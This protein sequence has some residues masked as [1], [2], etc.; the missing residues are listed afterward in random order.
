ML[1]VDSLDRGA[2]LCIFVDILTGYILCVGCTEV[3]AVSACSRASRERL[4]LVCI[5]DMV[6][7]P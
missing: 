6:V 5:Y 7:S 3:V 1:Q 4:L 2:D